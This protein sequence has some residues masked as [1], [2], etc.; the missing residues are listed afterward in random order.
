LARHRSP[1]GARANSTDRTTPI[2]VVVTT[3]GATR[4]VAPPTA[5][6][7]GRATV[8]AA[9]AGAAVAAGQTLASAAGGTPAA[10]QPE[11]LAPVVVTAMVPV[12][13]VTDTTPASGFAMN[14][15][16]GDQLVP[17]PG[18][19][20]LD[21]GSQVDVQNLAKAVDIGQELARQAAIIDAALADGADEAYLIGDRAYVRPT[22]G[23]LTSGFADPTRGQHFGIDVAAPIGTPIYAMT[24][25]VVEEAGPASGFGLWVVLRHAD[26]TRTIYG[27][28]HEFYVEKGQRVSAGEHIADVGNRGQSTGPHLHFEVEDADGDKINPT[29][30]L[31][32]HGVGL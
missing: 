24:D 21:P 27:H 10:S 23:R 26:G 31:N 15:I 3:P 5:S 29:A 1:Q 12:A 7:R 13:E 18:D 20:E 2:R 6:L 8:V 25:G 28:V 4:L 11:E 9:A 30:Y 19:L 16:G 14:A 17:D 32:D 22:T